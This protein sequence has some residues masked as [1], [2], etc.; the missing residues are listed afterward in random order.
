LSNIHGLGQIYSRQTAETSRGAT[1]KALIQRIEP[2]VAK[3]DMARIV[4]FL[5]VCAANPR[6]GQQIANK[7][8]GN[9][10]YVV[11]AYNTHIVDILLNVIWEQRGGNSA[12]LPVLKSV[13]HQLQR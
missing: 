5:Q 1:V 13:R 8:N 12:W 11:P 7:K 3:R 2:W 4:R 6:A 9:E 10:E